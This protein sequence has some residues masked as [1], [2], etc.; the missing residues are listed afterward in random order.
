MR[1]GR[2]ASDYHCEVVKWLAVG[3]ACWVAQMLHFSIMCHDE[4]FSLD[5]DPGLGLGLPFTPPPHHHHPNPNPQLQNTPKHSVRFRLNPNP[6]KNFEALR[7][8]P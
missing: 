7:A 6:S 5:T 2:G 4:L 8:L 3:A 1:V